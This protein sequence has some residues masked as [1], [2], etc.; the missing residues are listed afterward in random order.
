MTQENRLYRSRFDK[1]I[2]GVAGGLAKH[3]NMDPTLVRVLFVV[4]A[5][6]GAGGILIYIILWIAVPENPDLNS[7]SFDN[8]KKEEKM[9]T[10]FKETEDRKEEYKDYKD[11][12]PYRDYERRKND[13]NL[14]AGIILITLGGLFLATRFI[15]HVDFGDLWPL[16]LIVVGILIMKNSFSKP[17]NNV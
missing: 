17:K 9:E 4:L 7:F 5:F 14:I 8:T 2:A 13:G 11:Y 12:K 10:D 15:P 16:L 6:A 3:F 1:V